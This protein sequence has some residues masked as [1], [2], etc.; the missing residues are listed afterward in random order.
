MRANLSGAVLHS[1]GESFEQCMNG[2][3]DEQHETSNWCSRW[4]GPCVCASD[5][6]TS[7]PRRRRYVI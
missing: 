3:C 7:R 4:T 1:N 2:Q 6:R 5:D